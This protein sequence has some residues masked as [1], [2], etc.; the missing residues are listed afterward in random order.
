MRNVKDNDLVKLFNDRGAV[1]CAAQ[2]TERLSPG[3]IHCRQAS[4]VYE[5]IGKPGESA[6]RGG[7]INLLT[8]KRTQSLKTHS[9]AYNSCLIEI[10]KWDGKGIFNTNT[11]KKETMSTK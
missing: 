2:L 7:C 5:P 8:P 4:A 10:E 9:A 6:D 11:A 3:I 1:I